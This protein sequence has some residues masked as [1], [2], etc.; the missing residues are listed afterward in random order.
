MKVFEQTTTITVSEERYKE[1][2]RAEYENEMLKGVILDELSLG[3]DKQELTIGWG[4]VIPSLFKRLY[5]AEYGYK[6]N[7]L[8]EEARNK[9]QKTEE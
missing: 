1:L 9:Q 8:Q 7:L 2:V 6:L 3:Y 4:D 5:P